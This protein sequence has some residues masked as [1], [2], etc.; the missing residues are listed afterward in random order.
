M[1]FFLFE[2]PLSLFFF[3]FLIHDESSSL[4]LR[5]FQLAM[6]TSANEVGNYL[7]YTYYTALS[8][9]PPSL[10]QFYKNQSVIT[11]GCE[12]DLQESV[13][14]REVQLLSFSSITIHY[15]LQLISLLLKLM[16]ISTEY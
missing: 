12:D 11:Y 9:D 15:F 4:R 16:L 7:V 5:V 8:K 1:L 13:V 2:G 14:G 3:E 10:Y 6:L